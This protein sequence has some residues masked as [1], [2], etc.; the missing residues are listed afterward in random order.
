MQVTA[1]LSRLRMS[2]RKVR[3]V[4][5]LVRGMD[6]VEADAQLANLAKAAA[7]PMR[8]LVASAVANAVHNFAFDAGNLFI[9]NVLVDQGP[10]LK[11]F[12][13]RAFGRAATIRKRTSHITVVL[14]ERTPTSPESR[15]T[16]AGKQRATPITPTMVADRAT[17]VR[18]QATS[19]E[20]DEAGGAPT[21]KTWKQDA[22]K[23]VGRQRGFFRQFMNRRSGER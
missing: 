17:A 21:A 14:G 6:V 15:P 1:H 19:A 23:S 7:R 3:L 8:K 20:E 5:N 10:T 4:A 16:P 12:R 9:E 18:E 22:G 2:P 13:A 11:R